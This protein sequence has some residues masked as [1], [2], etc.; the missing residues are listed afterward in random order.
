ML[1]GTLK[2]YVFF[3]LKS[4]QEVDLENPAAQPYTVGR[5]ICIELYCAILM[6]QFALSEAVAI[7]SLLL[8]IGSLQK[9]LYIYS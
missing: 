8:L 3:A 5:R 9:Q 7:G 4:D 1:R 2:F 6:A